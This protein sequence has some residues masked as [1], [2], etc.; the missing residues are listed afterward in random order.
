MKDFNLI[1]WVGANSFRTSHY[2]YAEAIMDEADEQGIIVIDEVPA[3]GLS[4]FS[5]ELLALHLNTINELIARDKNRPS[6]FM[7]SIANEPSSN[8]AESGPYFEKVSA[9]ARRLDPSKRFI[10]GA[11]NQAFDAD[12]MGH[13]LDILMINRYYGWYSD[14]GYPQVI[15]GEMVHDL[16]NFHNKFKKPIM[17]S[18]Y[19]ADT[20]P[21]MHTEPSFIF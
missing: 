21:G 18:E 3:V 6:V 11:I 12:H 7:W 19:G 1:K 4:T 13:S 2:P 5:N 20:I 17:I 10:T 9:E 16:T 8:K 15:Q 14:A